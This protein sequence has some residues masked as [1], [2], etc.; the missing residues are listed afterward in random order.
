VKS[1][2]LKRFLGFAI[3]CL[4]VVGGLYSCAL[5]LGGVFTIGANDSFEEILAICLVCYSPFWSSILA[6]WNRIVAGCLLIFAGLYFPFGMLTQRSYMIHVR[7]F[8]EQP[9]V[10]ETIRN[11]LW[12]WTF[13]L[14]V[15]GT[16]W[17]LTDLFKW[18]KLLQRT[19]IIEAN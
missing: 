12:F 17:L 15:L 7:G 3:F 2:T 19:K 13:P 10:W 8:T 5:S 11:G 6:L 1:D 4:G 18:P 16:F 9:T 14:V